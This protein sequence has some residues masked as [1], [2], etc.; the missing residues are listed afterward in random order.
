MTA[1]LTGAAVVPAAADPAAELPAELLAA[2]SVPLLAG[3]ELEPIELP[4]AADEDALEAADS[5]LAA[6]LVAAALLVEPAALPPE[7]PHAAMTMAS[8]T[9]AV[10]ASPPRRHWRLLAWLPMT[11]PSLGCC[12]LRNHA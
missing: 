4:L 10:A 11:V 6:A 12:V 1:G 2:D 5:E 9:P 3:F 7:L 8:A